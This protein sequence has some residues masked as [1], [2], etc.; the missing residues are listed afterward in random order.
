MQVIVWAELVVSLTV[1]SFQTFTD[2]A[3]QQQKHVQPETQSSMLHHRAAPQEVVPASGHQPFMPLHPWTVFFK[4]IFGAFLR[5]IDRIVDR[6]RTV[7]TRYRSGTVGNQSADH[8]LGQ[9]HQ[10]PQLTAKWV[11]RVESYT[12]FFVFFF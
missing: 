9:N 5:L 12:Y 3:G 7:G 2:E 8:C 6:D 4:D 1:V 10:A 11:K